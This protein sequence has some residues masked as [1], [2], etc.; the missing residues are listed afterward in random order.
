[1]LEYTIDNPL[2]LEQLV[3]GKT[4]YFDITP[5][6]PPPAAVAEP[7]ADPA[8]ADADAASQAAPAETSPA[9]S[10]TEGAEPAPAAAPDA[11]DAS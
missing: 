3:I 10:E 4:Y 11:T 1:M 8:P 5:C 2:A 6:E 9:A 7:V